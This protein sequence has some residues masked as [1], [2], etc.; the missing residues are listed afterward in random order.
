MI[1]IWRQVG[2]K[3]TVDQ[4]LE[5]RAATGYFWGAQALATKFG[6]SRSA[7]VKARLADHYKDL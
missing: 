4:V 7:V 6:C 1:E 2:A 5:I 3:L